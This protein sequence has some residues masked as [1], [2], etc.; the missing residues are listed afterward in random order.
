MMNPIAILTGKSVCVEECPGKDNWC[1]P[2]GG[3][4]PC[5]EDKYYVCPYARTAEFNLRSTL[6]DANVSIQGF[7]E[8]SVT[9]G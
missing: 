6:Y 8:R 2:T 5:N 3:T 1:D 9:V 4:F 7:L